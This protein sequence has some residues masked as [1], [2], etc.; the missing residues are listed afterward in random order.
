MLIYDDLQK[1]NPRVAEYHQ[2]LAKTRQNLGMMYQAQGMLDE[3]IQQQ[4]LSIEAT[5]DPEIV[6]MSLNNSRS[7]SL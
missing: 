2:T 5:Q 4:R 3:A 7:D 6:A 1:D